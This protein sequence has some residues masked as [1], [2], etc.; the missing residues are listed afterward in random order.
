MP[1]CS[2]NAR[3]RFTT[4]QYVIQGKNHT[5][6]YSHGWPA[7]TNS[8]K[9]KA[10][11]AS[12]FSARSRY[13]ERTNPARDRLQVLPTRDTERVSRQLAMPRRAADRIAGVQAEV[14]LSRAELIA[15]VL[16]MT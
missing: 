4:R 1:P 15:M 10:W 7:S 16:G 2:A 12:A 6:T 3:R 9:I 11:A 13:P 8:V 5:R 14:G